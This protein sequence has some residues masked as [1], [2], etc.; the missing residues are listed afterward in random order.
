M[1]IASA[2]DGS[3]GGPTRR[4]DIEWRD[5]GRGAAKTTAHR[6]SEGAAIG[7]G[8]VQKGWGAAGKR[9]IPAI[10]RI[11]DLLGPFLRQQPERNRNLPGDH[12][13]VVIAIQYQLLSVAANNCLN[14]FSIRISL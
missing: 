13:K 6:T 12:R 11:L 1:V 7:A 14:C 10:R 8:R 3:G 2:Q 5:R 4:G 9:S